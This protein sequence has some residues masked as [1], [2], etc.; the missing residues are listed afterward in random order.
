MNLKLRGRKAIITGA[1][2][3]IG[4]AIAETLAAEGVDLGICARHDDPVKK[5]VAT[6]KRF[7]GNVTGAAIDVANGPS[8]KGWIS[9]AG[10]SLGGID[11]LVCNAS[12]MA[13]LN[14]E[15]DW[16]SSFQT[17]LMGTV[18]AVEA[19]KP[20]LECAGAQSGDASIVII[21]SV[22]AAEAFFESAYGATKAALI[23]FAKGIARREASKH[24]RANVVSPGMVYF[25]GSVWSTLEEQSPE[26]FKRSLGLNPM[27]R[28][29]SP[30]EIANAVAFLASP[31]SSFTSGVNLVIDGA[32]MARVNY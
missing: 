27:G 17:D 18:R 31:V 6:L 7:G 25:K 1:T 5:T 9:E 32:L 22:S 13:T 24:V 3:G 10:E 16:K 12:A 26:N 23:H 15:C 20:F 11:I 8:L 14:N 30:S 28:M 2:R 29:G 4:R 21:S 19:A